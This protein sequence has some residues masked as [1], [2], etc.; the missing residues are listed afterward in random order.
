MQS[1]WPLKKSTSQLQAFTGISSLASFS[2]NVEWGTVSNALL[3]SRDHISYII[4]HITMIY[5]LV[6]SISVMVLRKLIIVVVGE[7]VGL[8]ANWSCSF[9]ARVVKGRLDN[10]TVGQRYA[11]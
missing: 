9:S 3:K 8:N 1:E 6:R 11:P 7:P 5:G 4:Y 10:G 2:S